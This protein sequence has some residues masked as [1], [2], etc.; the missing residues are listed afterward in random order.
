MGVKNVKSK[1]T[2]KLA[3]TALTALGVPA[4][5]AKA[6]APMAVKMVVEKGISF[7]E[8]ASAFFSKDSDSSDDKSFG[9]GYAA[10]DNDGGF[11]LGGFE[12]GGFD[13]SS[14][15]KGVQDTID[16][17]DKQDFDPSK[18]IQNVLGALQTTHSY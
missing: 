15:A 16:F 3:T 9:V 18:S 11:S 4:P 12:L 8:L 2:N 5:I 17:F 10:S 7:K 1:I 6:I 13:P 14:I